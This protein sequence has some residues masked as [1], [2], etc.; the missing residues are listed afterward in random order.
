MEILWIEVV[1][2]AEA[3]VEFAAGAYLGEMDGI[4]VI[5]GVDIDEA[6]EVLLDEGGRVRANDVE[7]GRDRG[8]G[9]VRGR[10]G[11]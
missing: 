10:L 9:Q 6:I 4:D 2:G 8:A 7:G 5:G 3:A 11:R 1:D